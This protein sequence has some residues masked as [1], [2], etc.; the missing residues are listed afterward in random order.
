MNSAGIEFL[1][2]PELARLR[3]DSSGSALQIVDVRETWEYELCHLPGSIHIP[4]GEIPSRLN[5]LDPDQPVA[6][7]CHHG[8]RSYQVAMYLKKQDFTHVYNV[9]GGIDAWSRQVDPSCATY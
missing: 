1:S 5:E 2:T 7:L 6:C 4:M 3:T 8:V 9:E